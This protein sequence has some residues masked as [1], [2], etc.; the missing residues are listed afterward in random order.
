MRTKEEKEK[1]ILEFY[2]S[3]LGYKTFSKKQGIDSSTFFSWL[4][5]YHK[6]GSEGLK[7]KTGLKSGKGMGRPKKSTSYE[8]ELEIKIMKL[9]IENERLKKGYLVKGGGDQKEYVTILDK[10]MK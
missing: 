8:E 5:K 1:L 9:E 2:E 4:K 10:N 3:G 6:N 7:S